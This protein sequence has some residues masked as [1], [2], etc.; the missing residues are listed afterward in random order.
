MKRKRVLSGL[1]AMVMA[2]SLT[3]TAFA[4][5]IAPTSD[6]DTIKKG[7]EVRVTLTADE[8]ITEIAGMTIDTKYDNSLFAYKI[9]EK[10]NDVLYDCGDYETVAATVKDS[11]KGQ[12]IMDDTVRVNVCTT[13]AKG[14]KITQG[15]FVT[16]TFVAKE[17]VS[18]KK[19][20][21]LF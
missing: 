10:T 7:E 13:S 20:G 14:T 16:L 17:D 8:D 15:D 18:E 3:S 5:E 2:F 1:L 11:A 6:K 4:K 9:D 21:E 19:A 12:A